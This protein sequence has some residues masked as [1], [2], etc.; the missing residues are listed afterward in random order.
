M[1]LRPCVAGRADRLPGI[2]PLPSRFSVDTV[3]VSAFRTFPG[4]S[5]GEMVLPAHRLVAPQ[6]AFGF[7]EA[8]RE[9]RRPGLR[10]VNEVARSA[11][12]FP[13]GAEE[14]LSFP[15][16]FGKTSLL[17]PFEHRVGKN[18]PGGF[19]DRVLPLVAIEA[20]VRFRGDEEPGSRRASMD[21]VTPEAQILAAPLPCDVGP[22]FPPR[23]RRVRNVSIMAGTA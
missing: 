21:P 10:S 19:A 20:G 6:A 5:G 9:K 22:F 14:D 23:G 15:D 18:D 13:R 11:D 4:F 3:A 12:D 8:R 16:G 2:Y 7:F 1:P 17:H